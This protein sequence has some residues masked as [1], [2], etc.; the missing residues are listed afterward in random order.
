[1]LA[2]IDAILEKPREFIGLINEKFES[3]LV[4]SAEGEVNLDGHNLLASQLAQNAIKPSSEVIALLQELDD[5]AGWSEPTANNCWEAFLQFQEDFTR[6]RRILNQT[7]AQNAKLHVRF[8]KQMDDLE[9][10][11]KMAMERQ[12]IAERLFDLA[13]QQSLELD[14]LRQKLH[15]AI[16]ENPERFHQAPPF[17]TILAESFKAFIVENLESGLTFQHL[18]TMDIATLENELLQVQKDLEAYF[19]KYQA[20]LGKPE[21]VATPLT[22]IKSNAPSSLASEVIFDL[23]VGLEGENWYEVEQ[24]GRWA[25]PLNISTI[26]LP[27]LRGDQYEVIFEVVDA[28]NPEIL[29]GMEVSLNEQPLTLVDDWIKFP[30]YVRAQID[31]KTLDSSPLWEFRFKFHKLIRPTSQGSDDP[32]NLAIRMRSIKFKLIS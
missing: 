7:S 3:G 30:A 14:E 26:I 6:N 13:D 27:A 25:G 23:R 17:R 12:D 20:L 19:L 24:D 28:M 18:N 31:T 29:L 11:E 1:M 32:R 5:A 16:A 10:L 21:S 8:L 4:W 2:R 15:H 9:K 22:L